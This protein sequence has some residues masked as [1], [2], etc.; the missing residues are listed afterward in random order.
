MVPKAELITLAAAGPHIDRQ[1]FRTDLDQ[2]VDQ[3]L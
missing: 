3:S 2:L 1:Q